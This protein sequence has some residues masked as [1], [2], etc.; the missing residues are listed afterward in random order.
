MRGPGCE[1]APGDAARKPRPAVRRGEPPGGRPRGGG[2]GGGAEGSRAARGPQPG[3]ALRNPA[4]H[5]Q[6]PGLAMAAPRPPPAI[7]VSVSAP[8]FYAPQKKFGPV[9]APKPKVNP[10]RPGDNETP[11]AAG[12]QRAQIGRVGEIPPPPVEGMR[13]GFVAGPRRRRAGGS[14]FRNLGV[15]ERVA[16]EGAGRSRP[17]PSRCSYLIV[18]LMAG[19]QGSWDR[20]KSPPGGGRRECGARIFP[21]GSVFSKCNG[22]CTTAWPSPWPFLT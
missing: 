1:A 5:P 18:E 9:V 7:S 17:V 3:R 13:L 8:V 11:P 19:S 20:S 2:A 12:A 16:A 6:Q 21:S 10:F 4:T 22:S 14:G 15:S